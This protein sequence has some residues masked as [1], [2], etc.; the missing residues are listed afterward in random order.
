MATT[1]G[2]IVLWEMLAKC[3]IHSTVTAL[4]FDQPRVMFMAGRQDI[5]LELLKDMVRVDGELYVDLERAMR[6]IDKREAEEEAAARTPSATQAITESG[7]E[8]S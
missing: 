8:E 1:E 7:D 4:G 3:G 2:A 5:G 6:T